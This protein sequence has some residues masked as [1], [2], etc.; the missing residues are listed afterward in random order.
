MALED[1]YN[2]RPASE[3]PL[4]DPADQEQA[5][6]ALPEGV[7]PASMDP[8]G[9]PAD[10]DMGAASQAGWG[11]SEGLPAGVRPASEDPLGDPGLQEWAAQAGAG[12]WSDQ[13]AMGYYDRFGSHPACYGPQCEAIQQMPPQDFQGAA[14]QAAYGM[15]PEQREAVAGDLLGALRQKGFNLGQ[16][17]QVIGFGSASPQNIQPNDLSRLLGWAQQNQPDALGQAVQDKPWFIKQLGNPMVQSVLQ[18]LAARFL[19]GRG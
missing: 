19:G 9:D 11:Q 2:I 6:D 12:P 4:G 8:L 14:D 10:Q 18:K 3:D 7:L 15:P 17:A 16:L 5:P 13:Q 1:R